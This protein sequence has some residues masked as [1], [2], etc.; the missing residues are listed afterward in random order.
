MDKCLIYIRLSSF[1]SNSTWSLT[2]RKINA[3]YCP[4]FLGIGTQPPRAISETPHAMDANLLR[5]AI[6]NRCHKMEAKRPAL[7]PRS[8]SP[9]F[10][11]V[12]WGRRALNICKC[13]P[14]QSKGFCC[15]RGSF[16][17]AK[18]CTVVRQTLTNSLNGRKPFFLLPS[19]FEH[20]QHFFAARNPFAK[21]CPNAF[22]TL[23][24]P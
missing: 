21:L 5:F 17:V 6:T 14:T 19:N 7:C 3:I 1:P 8:S 18:V 23:K 20:D 12:L 16:K 13:L 2:F 4:S 15:C 24:Q 22:A 11:I 9:H 10:N